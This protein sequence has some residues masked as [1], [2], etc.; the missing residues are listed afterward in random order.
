[1]SYIT[2]NDITASISEV[3]ALL[4]AERISKGDIGR[5]IELSEAEIDSFCASRFK[6][7]FTN[8]TTGVEETPPLIRSLTKQLVEFYFFEDQDRAS[9]T[10][11]RIHRRV[12]DILKDLRNGKQKLVDTDGTPI[13]FDSTQVDTVWSNRAGRDSIFNLRDAVNQNY[14]P[15]DYK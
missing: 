4:E 12:L 9:E 15:A 7:P 14:N 3:G 8:Q 13:R 11:D 5:W 6:L 1:M 2:V 10:R